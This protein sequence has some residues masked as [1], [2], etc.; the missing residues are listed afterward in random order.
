M[1]THRSF[2][3]QC[4][5]TV[6]LPAIVMC[7]VL[8]AGDLR[9]QVV[10]GGFGAVGGVK[11]DPS[12]SLTNA[13]R[14]VL[15]DLP[16]LRADLLRNMPE[17]M[18]RAAGL[19]KVSLAGLER[20]IQKCLDG[21]QPLPLAV[22]CLAGLQGVQYV[23]VYPEDKD[24]VLVGP[25]EGWRVDNQGN[26]VGAQNGRPVMMLDDLVVALRAVAGPT[27]T[28]M[29]C[30]IDA[31]QEGVQRLQAA[32]RNP[33]PDPRVA[34]AAMETNLGPQKITIHGV[35][36]TSH[37]AQ[38]MVAADYHMKRVSLALEPS[39]V[40][41][42][43][44][45]MDMAKPTGRGLQHSLPRWWLEPAYEPPVR[46][47]QGLAWELRGA[48]VKTM[49]ETDFFDANGI[50]RPTGKADPIAQ[51]WANIMTERYEALSQAEPVFG[52]LRTCMDLA[53][54]AALL[55]KENLPAK[56]GNT[57]PHL[58]GKGSLD[59]A[60]LLAP[61]QVPCQA[62]AVPKGQT[63]MVAAGGV[64]INPWAVVEKAQTSDAVAAVRTSS[65]AKRTN[66]WWD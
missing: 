36:E 26:F 66:W 12:G 39:P 29:A 15:G 31:T 8:A 44:S 58:T 27:R 33:S 49:T 14:D 19:R 59:A 51:R 35:P 54:V 21:G 61:K 55:V 57:L 45:F 2:L 4:R 17:G 48:K 5:Q 62:M 50:A 30:S 22:Q 43:P 20:E 40:A 32:S 23:L 46:D 64:Q 25:A 42:L 16:K 52:Q 11:I 60:K 18:D 65:A 3:N 38:V 47:A 1:S 63:W 37:F 56:A 24:I 13:T 53:V 6:W 41:G 7:V 9:A 34:A 28:V 10:A